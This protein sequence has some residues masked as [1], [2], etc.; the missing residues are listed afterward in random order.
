MVPY[1]HPRA[2]G[3]IPVLAPPTTSQ[4]ICKLTTLLKGLG[5]AQGKNRTCM[6]PPVPDLGF[7]TATIC[8][9][10]ELSKHTA[11]LS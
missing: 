3:N 2:G 9:K 4:H 6:L 7:S 5:K 1:C 10:M 8:Q 11:A